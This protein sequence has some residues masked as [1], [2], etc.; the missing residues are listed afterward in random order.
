MRAVAGEVP[1]KRGESNMPAG[2]I[3]LPRFTFS[4]HP[5][6][7]LFLRTRR[8]AGRIDICLRRRPGVLCAFLRVLPLDGSRCVRCDC[9]R[10]PFELP[11]RAGCECRSRNPTAA[12]LLFLVACCMRGQRDR[13]RLLLK[14]ILPD[15][16]DSFAR[17][18]PCDGFGI[19]DK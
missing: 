9:R 13:D 7:G 2:Y 19:Q 4:R 17:P 8:A 18:C 5:P 3:S 1:P 6:R 12:R 11:G 15:T 16:P 10:A 14:S